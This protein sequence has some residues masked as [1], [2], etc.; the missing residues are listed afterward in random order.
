[1][2]YDC[3]DDLSKYGGLHSNHKYSDF[4]CYSI[5]ETLVGTKNGYDVY[6]VD[7]S[8][9]QSLYGELHEDNEAN[10]VSDAIKRKCKSAYFTQN[11]HVF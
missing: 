2:W 1:M 3:D 11:S 4:V 9:I 8:R 6:M 7:H 5:K 10:D